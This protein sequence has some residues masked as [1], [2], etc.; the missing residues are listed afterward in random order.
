[1]TGT[2]A[3]GTDAARPA[4]AAPPSRLTELDAEQLRRVVG[5]PTGTT[6]LKS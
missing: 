4:P 6:W 5:G 3:Q 2:N 1:M